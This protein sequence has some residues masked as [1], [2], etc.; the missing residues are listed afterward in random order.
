M[1]EMLAAAGGFGP[2]PEP[3]P[4]AESLDPS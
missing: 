4:G 3:D 1:N 2:P